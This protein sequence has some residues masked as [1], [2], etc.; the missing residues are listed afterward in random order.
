MTNEEAIRAVIVAGET[1]ALQSLIDSGFDDEGIGRAYL[2]AQTADPPL[3][4][5]MKGTNM[6]LHD[7][8]IR[9]IAKRAVEHGVSAVFEKSSYLKA[10]ERRSSEIRRAGRTD[11]R[12]LRTASSTTRSAARSSRPCAPRKG[13]KSRSTPCRT[14]SRKS[15]KA[16]RTQR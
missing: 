5:I 9:A 13:R 16:P 15:R 10:I 3:Q 14:T 12:R 2:Q 8:T 7:E 1:K 11:A 4:K 6:T